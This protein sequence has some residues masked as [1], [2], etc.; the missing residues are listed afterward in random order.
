[1]SSEEEREGEDNLSAQVAAEEDAGNFLRA[2]VLAEEAGLENEA[3]RLAYYGLRQMVVADR[4]FHGAEKLI[5]DLMREKKIDKD[6]VG[7]LLQRVV[8]NPGTTGSQKT[9][10]IDAFQHEDLETQ[11]RKFAGKLDI[12]LSS[13]T[14]GRGR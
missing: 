5:G 1:M 7:R 9:F 3:K 11:V 10:S 4:N 6:R 14:A 8:E 13:K 2:A 12:P